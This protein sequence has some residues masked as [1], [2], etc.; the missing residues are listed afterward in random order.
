MPATKLQVGT[1]R[2]R[3]AHYYMIERGR[4]VLLGADQPHN[5]GVAGSSPAPAMDTNA[6]HFNGLTGRLMVSRVC[7]VADPATTGATKAPKK[8][9]AA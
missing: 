4:T 2:H 8:R 6:R 1:G 9:G 7:R 3:A 5:A